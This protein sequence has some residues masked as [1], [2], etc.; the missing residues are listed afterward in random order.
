M[1]EWHI[2][3]LHHIQLG[4]PAGGETPA[5]E[6]YGLLLG[7]AEI[8]KPAQ[9]TAR[10][11]VWFQCGSIQLHLGVDTDFVPAKR[12]HPGLLVGN[13]T[14]L[15]T[16]LT[17]GGHEVKHDAEG[18]AGFDRAFTADPFGNRIELL[19]PVEVKRD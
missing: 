1:A 18:L 16:A 13:L 12:A 5:R 2:G 19:Q 10:G 4:M 14:E 6:F 17:A 11:G 3:G 7:L 9:L 15:I 8:A